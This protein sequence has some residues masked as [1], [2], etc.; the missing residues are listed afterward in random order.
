MCCIEEVYK[1][2]QLKFS[3]VNVY[4]D[5]LKLCVVCING[6]TYVCCSEC[7]AVSNDCYETNPHPVLYDISVRTV[8]K[9]YTLGVFV[10]RVSLVCNDMQC[11]CLKCGL[12]DVTLSNA[13][14]ILTLYECVIYV[15]TLRPLM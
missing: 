10:L 12:E 11:K 6:R 7:Y 2:L 8:V 9:L 15:Y 5:H 1:C 13:S 14:L 3:V 4:L